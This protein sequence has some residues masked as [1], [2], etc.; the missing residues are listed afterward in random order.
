MLLGLGERHEYVECGGCGTLQIRR[1]PADPSR[2]YG[3]GYYSFT[4]PYRPPAMRRWLKRRLA[5]HV[6]GHFDPVGR[7]IAAARP[8]P[9][10]LEWV[11][12]AGVGLDAAILDVGAG[13]GQL[14][15]TLRDYG[16]VRLLGVDPLL[17]AGVTCEDGVKVLRKGLDEVEGT[18]DLVMFHHS[19]EHLAD[20]A[21]ALAAARDRL[22]P[23]GCVLIR[24]PIAAESWRTYGASWV[25]LDAPRHL[26]VFTV[27]GMRMLARRQR[28]AVVDIAYDTTAFELWGSEQYAR[29]IPLRRTSRLG[30]GRNLFTA[31][32]WKRFE[33]RAR[34]L[35]ESGLAGR[36]AFW[37]R[38]ADDHPGGERAAADSGKA[39]PSSH[40]R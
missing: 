16:F 36:G 18:F 27:E 14:L 35:N 25:E 24:T 11:R 20:P 6:L 1:I 5:A 19:F 34:E 7:L 38:R 12:R 23:D 39:G 2:Y 30:S 22:S 37:L 40:E 21:A 8:L 26:H 28:M 32:E 9:R 4:T 3:P 17:D 15:L 13:S 33:A 10:E 31:E 29:N